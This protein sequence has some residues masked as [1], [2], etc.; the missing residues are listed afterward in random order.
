MSH[1]PE[2]GRL[3][4]DKD[5]RRK[6]KR[7]GQKREKSLAVISLDVAHLRSVG[8]QTKARNSSRGKGDLFRVLIKGSV[9]ETVKQDF[10]EHVIRRRW[11]GN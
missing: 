4:G 2:R 8:H 11:Q 1:I 3:A 5:R 9:T 7:V 10:D 6:E